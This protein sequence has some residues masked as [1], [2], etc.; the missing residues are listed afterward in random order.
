M[1]SKGSLTVL[2]A[3]ADNVNFNVGL[4]PASKAAAGSSGQTNYLYVSPNLVFNPA[5]NQLVFN[6]SVVFGGS[7]SYANGAPIG[8]GTT[9]TSN[10]AGG[11]SVTISDTPPTN[12]S[13]GNLWWNSVLGTMFIYYYNGTS[14]QWVTSSPASVGAQ[15]PTGYTG[16][17]GTGVIVTIYSVSDGPSVTINPTN[18]TIQLWTLG[19]SRTPSVSSFSSGNY[20]TL[21]ISNPSGYSITWTSVPVTWVGGSP[22]TLSTTANT[23]IELWKV[24]STIYGTLIGTA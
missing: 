17:L 21:F 16:S 24:N 4:Q 10:T 6:S 23:I 18:G 22:P 5:T 7:A 20:A 15:G 12:P 19:A 14:Y 3:V 8:S 2:P 13:A 1:L 9:I 11:T